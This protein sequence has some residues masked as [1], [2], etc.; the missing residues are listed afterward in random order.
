MLTRQ[1]HPKSSQAL[2]TSSSLAKEGL[3]TDVATMSQCA[4]LLGQLLGLN[5]CRR[6]LGKGTRHFP[7]QGK[8]QPDHF[9]STRV[10]LR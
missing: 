6:S 5:L 1:S 2:T 9:T 7:R 4:Q 8:H 3:A 10:C